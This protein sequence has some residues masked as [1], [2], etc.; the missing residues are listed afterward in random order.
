[1]CSIGG[2]LGVITGVSASFII[3]HY[4]D[5][6]KTIIELYSLFLALGVAM[7]VGVFFGWFPARRAA[8]LDTIDAL[9]YE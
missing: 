3:D 6:Y 2:I 9:R 1:M 5:K 8:K 7:A 4:S